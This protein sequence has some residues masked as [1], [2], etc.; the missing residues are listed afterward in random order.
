MTCAIDSVTM[1]HN[2]YLCSRY[3]LESDFTTAE[4]IHLKRV[5]VPYGSVS[6]AKQWA[7]K[8]KMQILVC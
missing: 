5:A 7:T 6:A 2:K 8:R 4:R 1:M 3:F